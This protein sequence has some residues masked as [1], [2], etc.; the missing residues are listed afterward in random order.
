[1]VIIFIV[2]SQKSKDKSV[3]IMVIIFIVESQKSKDKSLFIFENS[4][5]FTINIWNFQKKVVYL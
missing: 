4:Y 5:K 2:E 1:M 3:F